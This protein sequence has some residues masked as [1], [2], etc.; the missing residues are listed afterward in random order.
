[1]V[2]IRWVSVRGLD[3]S[4]CGECSFATDPPMTSRAAIE[5][6]GGRWNIETSFSWNEFPN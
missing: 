3:G 1:M 6:Y 2:S 4:R 5:I